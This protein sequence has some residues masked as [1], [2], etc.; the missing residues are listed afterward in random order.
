MHNNILIKPHFGSDSVVSPDNEVWRALARWMHAD[1]WSRGRTCA[2]VACLLCAVHV[3]AQGNRCWLRQE[4]TWRK[5]SNVLCTFRAASVTLPCDC[6]ACRGCSH[7]EWLWAW[8]LIFKTI[9]SVMLDSRM[10]WTVQGCRGKGK[11]LKKKGTSP[12]YG[13]IQCHVQRA[14]KPECCKVLYSSNPAAICTWQQSSPVL[15]RSSS[16][17]VQFYYLKCVVFVCPKETRFRL[18]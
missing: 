9:S 17:H 7:R 1:R 16:R 2:S 12:K 10:H 3:I 14:I 13:Q 5:W 6:N 11:N 4:H 15:Q 18:G 8:D